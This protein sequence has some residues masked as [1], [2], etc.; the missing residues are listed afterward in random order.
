[1]DAD[2]RHQLKQN[3]LAQAIDQLRTLDRGTI[4]TIVAVVAVLLL[5]GAFRVWQWQSVRSVE[6]RWNALVQLGGQ[7]G[8]AA[9][10]T[11]ALRDVIA[12]DSSPLTHVARLSLANVLLQDARENPTG[13]DANVREAVEVLKPLADNYQQLEP[14]IG[15]PALNLLA[16]AYECQRDFDAAKAVYDSLQS[17][18]FA[19][20]PFA[21]VAHTKFTD[22]DLLR[23]QVQMTPGFPPLD[24][25]AAAPAGEG[26]PGGVTIS[27]D[28]ARPTAQPAAT[29][30]DPA[31]AEA[32][33]D[34]PTE[35]DAEAD[36]TEA[37]GADEPSDPEQP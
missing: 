16:T 13:A 33:G 22:V 30:V 29:A 36:E 14:A 9:G 11:S 1:M 26:L 19:G 24:D 7:G 2:T 8:G 10:T 20:S 25:T 23:S 28:P 5:F 15:G 37:A 4:Y 12:G 35:D 34:L 32:A 27:T 18:H 31:D 17:E 3:E 6:S 21:E